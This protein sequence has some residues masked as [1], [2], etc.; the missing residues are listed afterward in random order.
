MA[1]NDRSPQSQ[2]KP[3]DEAEFHVAL[4]PKALLPRLSPEYEVDGFPATI[5]RH[6]TNDIELP[7][8]SV[9]RFHARLELQGN[10][11]RIVDLHSA[12]G[13]F[14]NGKRVQISPLLDQDLIAFGGVELTVSVMTGPR[15]KGGAAGGEGE[16]ESA[17][18]VHFVA[19]DQQ[20]VQSV[21]EADLP[22]DTSNVSVISDSIT[23][24]EQL[25][26]AKERLVTFYRLQEILRSTTDEK[27][28]LR[29]VLNLLF[30]VLPVDRGVVLTRDPQDGKL[31]NP[32]AIQVRTGEVSAKSI[33]ISKT[34]LMRCLK[35][36]IAIL[37]KDASMDERFNQADSILV[38]QIRSAMCVPLIS[39][40]HVFGFIHLDTSNSV[41]AFAKD[42]LAFLANV[43]VEV[44]IHLHNLRML[45]EK[46]LSERMAAIGQTITGLAHNIKNVLL[47]SQG[48]MD[49]MAKR[50]DEKS[51]D[52]LGETWS[53][54]KRGIDRINGMVKD[55]LDYSRARVA[56]KTRCQVNDLLK[57]IHETFSDEIKKRKLECTLEL[58]AKC[59]QIMLDADGLDK[60]VVNLLL[61]ALEACASDGSGKLTLRTRFVDET[62]L[63]IEVE[64]NAGG[65]PTEVLPRIFFPFFTTKGSQGN[66]LGLAMTKK[67]VED[68]GGRIDVRTREGVGTIF[69]ISIF[70]DQNEIRLESPAQGANPAIEATKV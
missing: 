43:G 53:L 31:F 38:N 56:E 61:N 36:K 47:L 57:E 21:V 26:R 35:E 34:I 16:P 22:D 48:G 32:V 42:D 62:C 1:V 59:P 15:V 37:S 67:F 5:G 3:G 39:Y 44:A 58:D 19:E 23:D 27:K 33:G 41:R 14:V 52:S 29:R 50:L 2:P 51:Y 7:F 68:M 65:I 18:S 13:T 60:A 20:V 63:Q 40:H 66:G 45:Q 70:M 49:L 10:K 55:M 30:Q 54:V 8:D 24:S 69:T 11:L 12:N 4:R 9:S 64:D 28:L 6:P 46:I 17:T 25:R